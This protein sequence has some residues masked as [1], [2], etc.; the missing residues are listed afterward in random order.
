MNSSLTNTGYFVESKTTGRRFY[1]DDIVIPEVQQPSVENQVLYLPERPEAMPLRRQRSKARTP[2]ISM[3]DIEGE[4]VITQRFPDMFEPDPS[5]V[6]AGD[7]WTLDTDQQSSA[8]SS[9]RMPEDPEEDWWHGGG[10]VEGVPNTSRPGTPSQSS[11]APTL[12]RLHCNVTSYIK[13]ELNLV[14]AA[15]LDQTLWMPTLNQAMLSR[16][17][18]EDQLCA[19]EEVTAVENKVAEEFLVTKTI[20]NKEVWESLPDWEPSI[21]AEY[22]LENQ[23]KAVIQMT[24][25]QLRDKAAAA[26]V[27]IELLPG[28]IVHTRKAQTG[29]YR[30]RAVICGNYA[31]AT[32][33]DVY[34]G[35]TDSTQVRVALKTAAMMHWKVMGTDIRTAF[36]NAKRRDETKFL[37]MSIPTVFRALGLAKEDEVWLVEMALYGLTT[38][39]RDWLWR[40]IEQ[41]PDHQVRWCGLLCVYVDDLL[42]C[43]EEG[44]AKRG[45]QNPKP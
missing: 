10:D 27:E 23:K 8:S 20:S 4:R 22:Q 26:G 45:H 36:L 44:A 32:E 31:S 33:Q 14:D 17:A 1:T 21:K 43:G 25:Q 9:S 24:Q 29:A 5:Y 7:S 37:A 3:L 19:L 16:V 28:K 41:G 42:F 2:A 12:R 39:P 11:R 34:A 30:S 35:G 13:E 38:S 40:L 15:S 6:D 18:L